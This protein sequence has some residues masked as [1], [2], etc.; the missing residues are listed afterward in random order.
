[1]PTCCVKPL[2]CCIQN[3]DPSLSQ[4]L[5]RL[6]PLKVALIATITTLALASCIRGP[7]ETAGSVMQVRQ[8]YSACVEEMLRSTCKVSN[9]TSSAAAPAASSVFVAGVGQIDAASYQTLRAAGDAMCGQV[10]KACAANW[11]DAACRTARSLWS[12]PFLTQ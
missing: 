6:G 12:P 11:S 9:D 10:R 8:L 7:V 3:R 1:M 4:V 2:W 5:G